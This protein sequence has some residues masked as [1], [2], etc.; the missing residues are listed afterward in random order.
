[1][2]RCYDCGQPIPDGHIVRRTVRTG[3][4]WGRS[5]LRFYFH[6]V[7]LCPE[8]SDARDNS[9]RAGLIIMFAVVSIGILA[10]LAFFLWSVATYL[11][12]N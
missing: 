9:E 5:S 4:S 8:C 7:N 12:G 11:K 2:V 6:K 3:T 10:A 1:M